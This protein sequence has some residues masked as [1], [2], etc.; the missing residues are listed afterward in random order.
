M[1]LFDSLFGK[2]DLDK[3]LEKKDYRGLIHALKSKDTTFR[4]QAAQALGK[5]AASMFGTN[6]DGMLDL[7]LVRLMGVK[8][9]NA[10]DALFGLSASNYHLEAA[11][12]LLE[13]T[14]DAD[15]EVRQAAV[16]ALG[17]VALAANN[18]DVAQAVTPLVISI[19]QIDA[20]LRVRLAAATALE[21][22]SASLAYGLR[23]QDRDKAAQ[24]AL[25]LRDVG[26]PAVKALIRC[27]GNRAI[28]ADAALAL[29]DIGQPALPAVLG[30][31]KN[32]ATEVYATLVLERMGD[33]ALEPL[34]DT[35]RADG[36]I[37]IM[38]GIALRGILKDNSGRLYVLA[39]DDSE[40]LRCAALVAL[41]EVPTAEAEDCI[42]SALQDV[43]PKVVDIAGQ[44]L[45]ERHKK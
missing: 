45:T 10:A 14:A 15:G 3:M 21:W 35:I 33:T 36:N 20:D 5:A 39:G 23:S 34:I 11:K 25:T 19:Y 28:A 29:V 41:G 24:Y 7:A 43:S 44:V 8:E 2:P 37:V 1:P 38:G 12:G 4:R 16:E 22:L 6:P 40:N 27:L 18:P 9:S 17:R 32:G 13:L 31:L 42:Q 30:A 26:E